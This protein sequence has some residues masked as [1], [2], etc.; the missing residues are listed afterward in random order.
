M[1]TL[2]EPSRLAGF[3]AAMLAAGCATG[4]T[5]NGLPQVTSMISERGRDASAPPDVDGLVSELLA[6]PLSADGAV[7]VALV[8]N[9]R[10]QSEYARLGIAAADVY[11]AGR[12]SNPTFSAEILDSN[13]PG[14]VSQRTF[15]I[16]QSLTRLILITASKRFSNGS[17]EHVPESVNG[18]VLHTEA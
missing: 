1:D 9:P 14:A 18:A 3:A 10:L 13:E 11:E 7:R 12:P 4:P 6:Q 17:F 15:G 5:D 16:A 2:I 8:N